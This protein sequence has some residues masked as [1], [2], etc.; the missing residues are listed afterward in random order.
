MTLFLQNLLLSTL[1]LLTVNACSDDSTTATP[2]ARPKGERT[3][4]ID[5][6]QAE[7]ENFD[8]AFSLVR[9]TG[10]DEI[11]LSLDWNALETNSGF[12]LSLIDIAN[13]FYPAFDWPITL[14]LR[15]INTNALTLPENLLGLP[16]DDGR[17]MARFTNLLDS[18]HDHA[19]NLRVNT[20]QIGN[21][22]DVY[23]A[24]NLSA[25]NEFA[26]FFEAA[27]GHARQLWGPEVRISTIATFAGA[28]SSSF[29]GLLREIAATGD[30]YSF[31]Y[32]PLNDDFTV[33]DPS[34]VAADF[35]LLVSIYDDQPIVLQECGY[36]SGSLCNS[37]EERQRAFISAVFE[38]WDGFREEIIHI[39]FTW[40]HDRPEV[41][42]DRWAQVYGLA[43]SPHEERFKEYLR[44]LGLRSYADSGS[45]KTAMI[46][47]REEAAARGWL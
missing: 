40:L 5:V 14:V 11:K 46:Q 3:F 13:V 32:Y 38:A 22:I 7:D 1:I 33:R 29:R 6:N 30:I 43:G 2:D 9:E 4:A 25:W 23:L 45:D 18:I 31:T 35:S 37:S 34:V 16:L 20:I 24:D 47:L 42:V 39:D 19:P 41:L 17:V 44:T 12:D 28:T 10:A 15:P 27:R 8:Q 36:P 26:I 21:E